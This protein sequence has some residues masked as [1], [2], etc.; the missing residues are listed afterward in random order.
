M[1]PATIHPAARNSPPT[2][3]PTLGPYLSW[4]LP[5]GIIK[6][7]NMITHSEKGVAI[8][9]LLRYVQAELIPGKAVPSSASLNLPSGSFGTVSLAPHTLHAYR[10][11]RH[12]LIAVP[13]KVTTHAF[14]GTFLMERAFNFSFHVKNPVF[15]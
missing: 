4:I 14:P 2:V 10:I 6:R 11:P 13:A 15:R 7:A 9:A 1:R 5:P 8:S 3:A 12:K